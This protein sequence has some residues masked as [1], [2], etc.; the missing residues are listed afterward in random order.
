VSLEPDSAQLVWEGRLLGLTVEQWGENER[1]IVEHPGAVAIVAV[2]V[3]GCVALVR[4]LREA[5]RKHLLELPAGTA[6]PGE[7][8]LE[9]AQR[10]LREECGLTGGEWR[11]LAAFWTTPGFC[12]ERMHLFA[13]EGVVLCPFK[14]LASFEVDDVGVFF[15]RERLVAE[16]VARLTGAPLMGI[17]GPS[18][19]G[20]SS[21][22]R[23][24]LLAALAAGMLPGSD[25]WALALLRPG[26]HPL[27]AL[28]QATA[29]AAPR[30]RL[31]IA[32]DQF[33][34]TF[35]AC[36]EESERAAFVDALIACARDP[37]RRAVVILAVRADFYGRCASYPELWRLL[38]ANQVTVGPMRRESVPRISAQ[39]C[40]CCSSACLSCSWASPT[41]RSLGGRRNGRSPLAASTR[42]AWRR[43]GPMVSIEAGAPSSDPASSTATAS[44]ARITPPIASPSAPA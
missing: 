16:M 9:T 11:E 43:S 26:E 13:A 30:G 2:D 35:T 29:G 24:G 21:A 31:V 40:C 44:P 33:E 23:A 6:E 42:Q 38:G 32:V 27:T 20:K 12:R 41:K 18:G 3:E 10:E 22:L 8:P 19:S 14:G 1:E 4:Q 15:G 37:G 39:P 17:V 28:E 25:R 7:V 5:T 34:E 36:R